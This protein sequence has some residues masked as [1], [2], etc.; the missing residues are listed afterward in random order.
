MI[1][2]FYMSPRTLK[3]FTLIEVL[4]AMLLSSIVIGMA[5][6]YFGQFQKY[7]TQTVQRDDVLLESNRFLFV[8]KF[9]FDRA[10]KIWAGVTD[11]LHLKDGAEVI[12][13]QFTDEEIMRETAQGSEI[14]LLNTQNRNFIQKAKYGDLISV[15]SFDLNYENKLL[16]QF[17]YWKEYTS[18]VL[19]ETYLK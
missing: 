1:R 18:G 15:V 7:L 13:Y 5:Y 17:F 3:A 2:I 10:D 12:I 4:V 11:E 6:L 19:T 14:F 8:I 16:D 9:D